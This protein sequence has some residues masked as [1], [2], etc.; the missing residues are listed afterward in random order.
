M[1]LNNNYNDKETRKTINEQVGNSYSFIERLKLRG[2]GSKRVRVK[3][4]SE[5]LKH[6]FGRDHGLKYTIMELRPKGIIIYIKNSLNEYVWLIPFYKLAIYQSSEF[7]IHGGG[8]FIKLELNEIFP[9]NKKFIDK[10]N[11]LKTAFLK[12]FDSPSL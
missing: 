8:E 12:D 4:Y 6:M 5:G 9:K 10:L 2:I 3:S 7:T 11:D 1:I